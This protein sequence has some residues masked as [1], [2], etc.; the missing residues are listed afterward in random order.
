MDIEKGQKRGQEMQAIEGLEG[1]WC[2]F[3]E[4]KLS[5]HVLDLSFFPVDIDGSRSRICLKK[6]KPGIIWDS[7]CV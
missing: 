4:H 6:G 1:T 3:Q 7:N 2:L 5:S